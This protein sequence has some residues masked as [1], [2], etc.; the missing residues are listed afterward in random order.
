[1]TF[2]WYLLD[3]NVLT[4]LT[5]DQRASTFVRDRCRIP[6]EVLY[7]AQGFPDIRELRALEFRVTAQVLECVREVMRT[8][9]PGDV[10]LVDLYRNKGNADPLI[11]ATALTATRQSQ[12]TLFGEDWQV[13]TDDLGIRAKASE[14]GVKSLGSTELVALL[15]NPL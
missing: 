14:L 12:E 3:N 13:V 7:E 2:I 9:T 4:K 8:L 6:T 5:R 1:M 15:A 10:K 11:I